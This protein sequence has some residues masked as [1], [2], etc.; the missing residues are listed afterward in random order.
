MSAGNVVIVEDEFLVAYQLEDILTDGGYRVVATVPDLA[1]ADAVCEQADLALVD[2]NLRDGPTGPA[3]ARLLSERFGTRIVY[4]TANAGQICDP[5]A[6]ALGVV[7]KP[8]SCETIQAVVAFALDNTLAIPR[9]CEL[10]VLAGQE[11]L[12]P[13]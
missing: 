4:V 2:L 9:P 7:N 13:A 5:A 12:Q 3:I 8:F 1:A 11:M 6:T 10:Q